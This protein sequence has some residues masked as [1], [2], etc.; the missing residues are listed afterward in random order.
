MLSQVTFTGDS[1]RVNR[2][3]VPIISRNTTEFPEYFTVSLDE[4][5]L[6]ISNNYSSLHL[7]DQERT[8]LVLNP[9]VANITV[10]DINGT[11]K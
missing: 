5:S 3:I 9:S 10:V 2:Q 11:Y 4:V 6:L 1:S 8:R 7:S